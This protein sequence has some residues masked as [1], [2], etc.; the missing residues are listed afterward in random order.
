MP[1]DEIRE[2]MLGGPVVAMMQAPEPRE[3]HDAARTLQCA[4]NAVAP[5]KDHR[6]MNPR[7]PRQRGR[8]GRG[9]CPGGG[10][11]A[12]PD[13]DNLNRTVTVSWIATGSPSRIVGSYFLPATACS[14]EARSSAGPL[15]TRA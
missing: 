8:E 12:V 11:R 10:A 2:A 14:A 3:R 13:Q 5:L 9:G 15:I 7:R 6:H 4:L 1:S